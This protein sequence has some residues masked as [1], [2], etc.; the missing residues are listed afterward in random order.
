MQGWKLLWWQPDITYTGVSGGDEVIAKH[1]PGSGIEALK[2]RL[3]QMAAAD[4]PVVQEMMGEHL[5]DQGEES[6]ANAGN[7]KPPPKNGCKASVEPGEDQGDAAAIESQQEP[8]PIDMAPQTP[9]ELPVRKEFDELV[10]K[11][12]QG[13]TAATE[14]VGTMLDNHPEIWRQAGDLAKISEFTQIKA[15]AQKN[16]LGVGLFTRY[17]DALKKEIAGSAPTPLERLAAERVVQTWMQVEHVDM[18]CADADMP[19]SQ[20]RFWTSRQDAAHRRFITAVK[21]LTMVRT[22]LPAAARQDAGPTAQLPQPQPVASVPAT[23]DDSSGNGQQHPEAVKANGR[24]GSAEKPPTA[25]GKPV[26]RIVP[27]LQPVE[28]E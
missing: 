17:S 5:A 6:P 27:M 3:R 8:R 24:D 7:G 13:D 2:E 12:N 20:L 19:L 4:M 18:V 11:M 28:V 1:K 16:K 21:S 22:L 26:N 25:N 23:A 9:S 10:A 14:S 15:I